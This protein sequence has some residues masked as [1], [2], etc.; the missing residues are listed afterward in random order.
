MVIPGKGVTISLAL[1]I[2]RS[3][4]KQKSGFA[5]TGINNQG[6]NNLF[7]KSKNSLDLGYKSK[8]ANNEPTYSCFFLIKHINKISKRQKHVRSN[9]VESRINA[10]IGNFNK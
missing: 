10:A 4:K 5:I 2:K 8:Q 3:N 1:R 6:F 7:K 9:F